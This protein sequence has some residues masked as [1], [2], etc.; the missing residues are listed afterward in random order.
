MIS[1]IH[2]VVISA[3]EKLKDNK[4][5]KH[6]D[7]HENDRVH[8]TECTIAILEQNSNIYK[9]STLSHIMN[10][11]GNE[12]KV[13]HEQHTDE[14]MESE[15]DLLDEELGFYQCKKEYRQ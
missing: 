2:N 9:T 14:E 4:N 10:I 12:I 7:Y 3:L 1:H 8:P 15:L 13:Y 6:L 5:I 11:S